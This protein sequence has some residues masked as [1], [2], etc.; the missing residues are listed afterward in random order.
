MEAVLKVWAE[1]QTPGQI[2][3][4]LNITWTIL[5]QWQERALEG[6]LQ[7]LEPRAQ[8]EKGAALSP[9]LQSLLAKKQTEFSE[10]R[11]RKRFRRTSEK[12]TAED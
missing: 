12:P 8:L 5:S 11:L 2:C 3:R 6:M 1:S 9:R 10:E 4:E 7:A